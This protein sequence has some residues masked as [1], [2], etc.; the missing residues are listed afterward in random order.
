MSSRWRGITF[1]MVL[2]A[3]VILVAFVLVGE[4]T[5]RVDDA[6][7]WETRLGSPHSQQ[8]LTMSDSLGTRGRPD[9]RYE[10]WRM[11]N[12]GFRGEDIRL[13][14]EAGVTRVAVLGASETFGLQESEGAEYPSRM[15]GILDSL[16][17]GRFEVVNTALPG[18]TMLTMVPYYE[19]VVTRIAPDVVVIYPSPSFYLATVPLPEAL[20]PRGAVPPPPRVLGLDPT[21]LDSRLFDRVK[22]SLKS[23]IPVSAITG[24]REWKLGRLRSAAGADWV[25]ESTPPDR[26]AL[27]ER[28]LDRLVAAVTASGASVMLVTHTNRFICAEEAS[29]SDRRHLINLMATSYPRASERVMA[30]IDLDANQ[31]IRRV[32]ERYGTTLIEA[33]GR[34]PSS[35]DYFVDYS[36]FTDLGA[37]LM[38]R[39]VAQGVLDGTARD[40]GVR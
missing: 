23:L 33:E 10:K 18:M 9:Y 19:R 15:Q 34:I 24:Y 30:T 28:H 40:A 35:G 11:N 20:P 12:Q 16:A 38:A 25:W 3:I 6:L 21:L 37:D 14:P 4:L 31:V 17:S 8:R 32:A 26:M 29:G 27:F 7:Y 1:G 22:N 13:V 36:H 39:I 5:A 2:R